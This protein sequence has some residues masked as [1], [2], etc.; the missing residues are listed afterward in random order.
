M[1]VIGISH[2]CFPCICAES[3]AYLF[4][5]LVS[6]FIYAC[7]TSSCQNSFIDS[8]CLPI[9][10]FSLSFILSFKTVCTVRR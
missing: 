10:C 2:L 6:T 9:L 3:F 5:I 4:N 7:V 1:H 8:R